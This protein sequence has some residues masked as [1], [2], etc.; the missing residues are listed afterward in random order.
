[1]VRT[2]WCDRALPPGI[3]DQLLNGDADR[4]LFSAVPLQVKDR[5]VVA[6]LDHLSG[7]L[8]MKR[9]TW[10]G[11]L[12]T[13]RMGWREAPSRKC[14]RLAEVLLQNGIPTPRPRACLEYRIGPHAYCSYLLTDFVGGTSL[15]RF[16]RFR[17]HSTEVLE[18]LARQVAAIWERLVELGLSHCDMK[19]ENFIVDPSHRVWLIDLERVRERV[20][21]TR[22]RRCQIADVKNFLHI[23]GWHNRPLAREIFAKAILGTAAAKS[24]GSE[25]DLAL[26]PCAAANVNQHDCDL[27]VVVIG[28]SECSRTAFEQVCESVRDIAD[29]VVL[30]AP[31]RSE[32]GMNV[33]E[34]ITLCDA[35]VDFNQPRAVHRQPLFARSD[36]VLV[37]YHG[38]WSTPVLSRKIQDEIAKREA[39]DAYLVFVTEH[40]FGSCFATG[41]RTVLPEIRLFRQSSCD[42][43]LHGGQLV[44]TPPPERTGKLVG[45]IQKTRFANVDELVEW[46]NEK[47]SR[48]AQLRFEAG[49][50]PDWFRA[51][52][53]A[54]RHLLGQIASPIILRNGWVGV[55]TAM[56]EAAFI[57]VEEAKLA[58]MLSKFPSHERAHVAENT[59]DESA[60][61][62]LRLPSI[63][64]QQPAAKAA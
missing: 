14:A 8:L 62:T 42:F 39:V 17:E 58:Q 18:Q 15:Y 1:M 54:V 44:I 47:M 53:R 3:I 20:G 19:P 32:H 4:L 24:L 33:L 51:V 36:W 56:L 34:R 64:S 35:A 49:E 7:S 27:S 38:E 61:V 37:L 26:G 6:R 16:I 12:R 40:L 57:C 60:A 2:A 41:R 63:A 10:G 48:S 13:L 22:Q 11:W 29:E 30:A 21:T 50:R 9:H 55:Q 31:A 46:L 25:I 45:A 43:S 23:R 59:L 5:C 52:A 28:N